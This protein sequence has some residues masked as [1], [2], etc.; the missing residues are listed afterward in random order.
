MLDIGG[1]LK[2]K[3]YNFNCGGF[4]IYLRADELGI[5]PGEV[6]K[7]NEEFITGYL[8]EKDRGP[9]Y[10]RLYVNKKIKNKRRREVPL[11]S[12][13]TKASYYNEMTKIVG[14]ENFF[15]RDILVKASIILP[16]IKEGSKIKN[17]LIYVDEYWK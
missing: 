16:I 14:F 7:S 12:E 6:V 9:W 11:D 13:L 5:E 8:D 10:I 3:V 17:S 4:H 1:T 2:C 15:V